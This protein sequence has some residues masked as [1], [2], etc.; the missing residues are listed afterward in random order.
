M[1]N[2]RDAGEWEGGWDNQGP[3]AHCDDEVRKKKIGLQSEAGRKG[4]KRFMECARGW[5]RALQGS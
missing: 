4:R 5:W 2:T 3:Q 1:Q